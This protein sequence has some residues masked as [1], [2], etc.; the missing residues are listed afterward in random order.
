MSKSINATLY[1]PI[2]SGVKYDALMPFSDCSST[3]LAEGDTKVAINN[4]AI[5]SRKY[6]HHT[7]KI[8]GT[9]A[10]KRLSETCKEIHGFLFHHFQ[11]KIDGSNQNLRSPACSWSSRQSGIDCKS[12]SIFASTTLLNLGINHYLRRIKQSAT[13]GFSHV[14]V[15]V[16]KN[17][18]NP[19]NLKHGYFIID[20]TLPTIEEP[21]FYEKSDIY[22][23]AELPIYGLAGTQP[24]V[25]NPK[26]Q[27]P[28]GDNYKT[29][30]VKQIFIA[31]K[32]IIDEVVMTLYSILIDCVVPEYQLPLIKV[33]ID[34]KLKAPLTHKLELLDEAIL[35]NN[36]PRIQHILND[37]FKEL[38]LGIAH[39]RN[40]AAYL[41]SDKCVGKTLATS[42][43]YLEQ[44]KKAVDTIYANFIKSYSKYDFEMFTKTAT[45][46]ERTLY[47][48]VPN[49]QSPVT[50]EYRFIVLRKNKSKYGIEPILPYGEG[51]ETFE[52]TSNK[53]L[54]TNLRHLRSK[55]TDGRDNRYES[56]IKP[57]IEKVQ[58][59]RKSAHLGGEFLYLAEQ[60]LQRDMYKI[61]LKYDTQY[62]DFL[63]KETQSLRT[64]NELAMRDFEIR[65]TSEVAKDKSIKQSKSFKKM[66]GVGILACASVLI[67]KK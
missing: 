8:A 35:F 18:K 45:T 56:E 65:L 44:I 58:N 67:I 12:Y 20:G 24:P 64:A 33:N 50:A 31:A 27:N 30:I 9:F 11:Y 17:Q 29:E 34:K 42:L 7:K 19:K 62:T 26:G 16:P 3:K 63:K 36:K 22:M 21:E 49:M 14:Y 51:D 54:N 23:E 32:P 66:F 37:I 46:S 55:Y 39:L 6:K 53:W 43:K 40:E 28:Q 1:R 57:Y 48:V 59:L 15:I 61:W 4:M 10:D 47:F 13:A 38:D 5:W 2:K 41:A 60:P 52:G 25:Q